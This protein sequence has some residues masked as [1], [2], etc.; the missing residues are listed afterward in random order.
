MFQ[1]PVSK[2][3]FSF[4]WFSNSVELARLDSSGTYVV[5]CELGSLLLFCLVLSFLDFLLKKV[6]ILNLYPE[7]WLLSGFELSWINEKLA[8]VDMEDFGFTPTF[9]SSSPSKSFFILNTL[10]V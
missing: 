10:G 7:L 1:T 8:F 6:N 3:L 5:S 4:T 9:Y 2:F